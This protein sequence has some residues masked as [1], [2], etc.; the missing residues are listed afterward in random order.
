MTRQDWPLFVVPFGVG[1]IAFAIVQAST[2]IG[3]ADWS[4]SDAVVIG[5][6]AL[7]LCALTE[8]RVL[9]LEG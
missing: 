4:V 3:L 7:G 8:L 2:L 5:V 1:I 9:R 6:I